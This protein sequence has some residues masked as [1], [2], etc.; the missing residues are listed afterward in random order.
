MLALI[1]PN[2][3]NRICQI[4]EQD[5]PVAEPLFWIECP[6]NC[7]TQWTYVNG[8]FVEPEVIVESVIEPTKEQLL[9]EL[10]T[11]TAKIQALGA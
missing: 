1:S 5:F 3:N 8:Q 10:Q 7:T 6:D 11:L 9:A 4:E 2:E